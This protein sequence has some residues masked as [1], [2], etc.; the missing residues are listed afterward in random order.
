MQHWR[1]RQESKPSEIQSTYTVYYM[2]WHQK[3]ELR[4]LL[5]IVRDNKRQKRLRRRQKKDAET[6][7]DQDALSGPRRLCWWLCDTLPFVCLWL[8]RATCNQTG[9]LNQDSVLCDAEF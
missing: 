6:A 8:L 4:V 3:K 2:L 5:H 7:L 9:L 1:P